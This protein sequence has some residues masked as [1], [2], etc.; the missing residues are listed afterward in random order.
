M[1]QPQAVIV[2]LEDTLLT[3][4]GQRRTVAQPEP[5]QA[6]EDMVHPVGNE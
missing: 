1:A 4:D 5:P 2:V 3:V 6:I